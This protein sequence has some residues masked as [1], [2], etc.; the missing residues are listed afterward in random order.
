MKK[1]YNKEIHGKVVLVSGDGE[2]RMLVDFLIGEDKFE[3]ILF[4][5]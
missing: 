4:P 1:M 2:Y 3:K 5:D